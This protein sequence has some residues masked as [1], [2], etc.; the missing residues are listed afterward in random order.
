MA[1]Y[2]K[3]GD[4]GT[5]SLY[6]EKRKR[7]KDNPRITAY[8]TVDELN[9]QLGLVSSLLPNRRGK[10]DGIIR[11]LQQTLFELGSELATPPKKEPPFKI[12]ER[13]VRE[14]ESFIDELEGRLSWSGH[15]VL[16][17][18][19]PAAAAA[20][21]ARTVARRAER[22]IVKLSQKEEVNPS[23]IKYINRLSDLIY[24]LARTINKEAGIEEP[25]W[26]GKK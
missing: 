25:V 3:K 13:N 5:T 6:G 8:G 15:F 17:G 16:P 21:I 19:H 18:G 9:S 7:R 4:R 23:L 12:S 20:H 11:K 22:E 1:V 10:A 24:V 2:T 14:L 26:R